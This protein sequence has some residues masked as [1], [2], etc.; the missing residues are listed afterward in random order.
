MGQWFNLNCK[1][2]GRQ[3]FG[4]FQNNVFAVS[5][6]AEFI[7]LVRIFF[8]V[9]LATYVLLNSKTFLYG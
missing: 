1:G 7:F 6:V 8:N 2:P 9:H 4:L 5:G 3:G